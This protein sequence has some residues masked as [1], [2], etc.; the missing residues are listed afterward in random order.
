MCIVYCLSIEL[1]RM[2]ET[3]NGRQAVKSSE[4]RTFYLQRH[5]KAF[6]LFFFRWQKSVNQRVWHLWNRPGRSTNDMSTMMW[7]T[8]KFLFLLYCFAKRMFIQKWVLSMWSLLLDVCSVRS[9]ESL[10]NSIMNCNV[11]HIFSPSSLSNIWVA[12]IAAFVH[13]CCRFGTVWKYLWGSNAIEL[14]K[15]K[16]VWNKQLSTMDRI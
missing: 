9:M 12:I 6:H 11:A 14:Y 10:W 7:I 8:S 2:M 4:N 5:S 15:L 1:R 16:C 3:T 13:I